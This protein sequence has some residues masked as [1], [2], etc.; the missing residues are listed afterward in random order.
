MTRIAPTSPTP[1]SGVLVVVGL[2]SRR[3]ILAVAHGPLAGCFG[4]AV[5]ALFSR[6]VVVTV[7]RMVFGLLELR[8]CGMVL[9]LGVARMAS[10]PGGSARLCAAV[11]PFVG[12]VWVGP[13][14]TVLALVAMGTVVTAR[15]VRAITIVVVAT[16]TISTVTND[17][18]TQGTMTPTVVVPTASRMRTTVTFFVVSSLVVLLI[19]PL[20]VC[21]PAVTTTSMRAGG[22]V[23]GAQ[24]KEESTRRRSP[25]P[26]RARAREEGG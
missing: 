10:P 14:T 15:G 7:V 19:R 22:W 17:R 1:S 2:S 8:G 25:S 12:S 20:P 16:I 11:R 4:V 24:E 6:L 13:D 9:R 23:Q 26:G 18:M 21:A 5:G 3:E